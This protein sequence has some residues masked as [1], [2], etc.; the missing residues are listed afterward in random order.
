MVRTCDQETP[1]DFKQMTANGIDMIVDMIFD[2]CGS[3]FV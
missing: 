3:Q 1:F 2:L